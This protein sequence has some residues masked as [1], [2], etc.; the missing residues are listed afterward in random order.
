[1]VNG[2]DKINKYNNQPYFIIDP[3]KANIIPQQSVIIYEPDSRRKTGFFKIWVIMF[4]NIIASRELIYQL[5]KRDFLMSY[6]K[7]FFGIGWIFL[8]PVIGIISWVFMNYRCFG[9]G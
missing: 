6:K 3:I 7:S 4:R 1:M 2:R 9:A 8:A 5:F